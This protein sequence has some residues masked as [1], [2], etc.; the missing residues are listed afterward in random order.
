[1]LCQLRDR[2]NINMA[3]QSFYFPGIHGQLVILSC[4]NMK[5]LTGT[6]LR[7][8]LLYSIEVII[9]LIHI[10]WTIK[11]ILAYFT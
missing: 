7:L 6:I 11:G 8:C 10:G 5:D 9:I 1:M 2:I 3:I 4:V